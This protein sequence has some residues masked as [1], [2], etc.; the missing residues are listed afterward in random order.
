MDLVPGKRMRAFRSANFRE[1]VGV[2]GMPSAKM[3]CEL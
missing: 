2:I 3:D 1:P